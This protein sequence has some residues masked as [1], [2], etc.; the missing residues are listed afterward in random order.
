MIKFLVINLSH[1]VDRK[2]YITN[3]LNKYN[4][5]Y[6]IINAFNGKNINEQIYD[7]FVDYDRMILEHKRKLSYG[8]IGCLFSHKF[9]LEKIVSDNLECAIIIEDDVFFDINLINF[10]REKDKFP[11]DL[12]LLMLGH[13]RQVYTD[14][15]FRIESPYSKRFCVNIL[16][17]KIRR[18]VGRGNGG[19]GYFITNKG[20]KKLLNYLE[21][22]FLPIDAIISNDKYIN[23]YAVFP[24][25]ITT[26][27]DFMRESSTQDNISFLKKRNI[28][29]KYFKKI[30]INLKYFIPSIKKLKK[31]E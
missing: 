4:L 24:V 15:N 5:D 18:L 2:I 21:H 30:V 13:Q 27:P 29:Q 22:F 6:E 7:S 9:C 25:L 26:H 28:F 16:N 11:N 3:I 19:Y 17:Y 10:I 1:A 31:Y 8:E 12:E 20:A 14:T 23:I